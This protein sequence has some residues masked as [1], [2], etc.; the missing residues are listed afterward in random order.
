MDEH[1]M[2]DL[3]LHSDLL[4][5]PPRSSPAPQTSDLRRKTQRQHP[6]EAIHLSN[7]KGWELTEMPIKRATVGRT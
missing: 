2:G 4:T 1:E 3:A 7:S 6:W 5:S